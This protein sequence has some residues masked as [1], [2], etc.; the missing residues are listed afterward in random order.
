MRA[1]I[2][3]ALLFVGIPLLFAGVA[4]GGEGVQV[5]ITNDGTQ[6]VVVTVYDLNTRPRHVVLENAHINGFTSVPVNVIAD[7]AGHAHI[8]WIATSTDGVS[9][10]CGHDNGRVADDSAINVHADASCDA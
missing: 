10:K 2:G 8:E 5:K 7:A 9:V 3:T 4:L 6:D 1:R